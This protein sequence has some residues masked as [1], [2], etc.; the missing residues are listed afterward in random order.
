MNIFLLIQDDDMRDA[1]IATV[2]L[3]GWETA[4]EVFAEDLPLE[5]YDDRCS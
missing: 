4:E 3:C 1:V 5:D 2:E